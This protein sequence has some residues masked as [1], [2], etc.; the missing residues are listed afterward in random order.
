MADNTPGAAEAAPAPKSTSTAVLLAISL[1]CAVLGGTA[2]ALLIAPKLGAHGAPAPDAESTDTYDEAAHEGHGGRSGKAGKIFRL[3]NMI[4]NPAG[5]EGTRFLMVSVAFEVENDA[6]VSKLREREIELRD[7]VVGR[8]EAM[9]M[10]ALTQPFAR[11][12][13]KAQ[14]GRQV[15]VLLGPRA[16]VKVYLPQFV[17]Q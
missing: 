12:T 6:A 14:L 8:L 5:S 4:V 1:G 7:M 3:D 10:S 11:D 16:K 2:G 9:T 17:I 15:L 13:L